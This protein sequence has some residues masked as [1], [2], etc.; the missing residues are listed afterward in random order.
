M[1]PSATS[2][3]EQKL[4]YICFILPLST[5]AGI[6]YYA[7]LLHSV[8]VMRYQYQFINC[9]KKTTR[10]SD[11]NNENVSEAYSNF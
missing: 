4:I 2:A 1:H 6:C 10:V 3:A 8:Q 7:S 5:S 11:I 9:D